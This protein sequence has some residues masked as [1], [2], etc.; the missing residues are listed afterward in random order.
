MNVYELSFS[1][2]GGTRKVS[3]C[4]AKALSPNP[5]FV[6]LTNRKEDFSLRTFSPEDLC[7]AAVPSYGGR[8]PA[9]AADRLRAMKGQGARVV[10]LVVYGN[11]AY[12][13]TLLELDEVTREAGFVPV[14]GVA[15]VAEH[16][17]VRA[18]GQGRPDEAD[19]E[20]LASFAKTILARLDQGDLTLSLPG[21]RPY[22]D[23]HGV[24]MKPAAGEACT[25][26]GTCAKNCPVGAIPEETPAETDKAICISCMRCVERCPKKARTIGEAA[27]AGATQ[28]LQKVCSGRKPN[29][30][31]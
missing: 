22:V 20:E 9:P 3:D 14:A 21:K 18:F 23:Y 17:I 30:L 29:E 31:F 5:V 6:D 8:V 24:P 13:D 12:D 11:R 25:G 10:L 7:I 4:L 19:R 1:P 27:L 28:M 26:C 15:A 2:T 16:S